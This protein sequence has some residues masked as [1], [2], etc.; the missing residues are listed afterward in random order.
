MKN[1]GNNCQTNLLK[2]LLYSS[3]KVFSRVPVLSICKEAFC[4][5]EIGSTDLQ[6]ANGILLTFHVVG[7][8]F[9]GRFTMFFFCA[10]F[11]HGHY[12]SP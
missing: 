9:D 12:Q 8:N 6:E 3:N 10:L 11:L 2:H 1:Y 5:T 4:L 7:R